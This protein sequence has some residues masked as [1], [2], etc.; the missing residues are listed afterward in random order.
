LAGGYKVRAIKI[1]PL[2]NSTTL[3]ARA[4]DVSPERRQPKTRVR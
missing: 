1:T 3:T 4:A 2:T